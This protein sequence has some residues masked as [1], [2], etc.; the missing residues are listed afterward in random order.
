M[1][2]GLRTWGASGL[3]ELDE[4]S[5]TVMIV[6]S[7]VFQGY[8]GARSTFISIPEVDPS[9]H[10]AVCVPIQDY[11]T[12]GQDTSAIQYTPIVSSG[13]VIVHFGCPT[14]STGPVGGPTA[15]RL[16]VMRFR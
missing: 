6:Y 8:Q 3:P 9:T 10:S 7:G 5:F 4:N 13:G 2:G 15:Q 16:L 12:D 11:R 1:I 14:T